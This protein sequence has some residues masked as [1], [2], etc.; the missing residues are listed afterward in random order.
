MDSYRPWRDYPSD[1]WI[2]GKD[3]Q[4]TVGTN[5]NIKVEV[6]SILEGYN[7]EG[8]VVDITN[9]ITNKAQRYNE[10]AWELPAELK[11]QE[12]FINWKCNAIY[13]KTI[14]FAPGMKIV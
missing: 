13:G 3:V 4:I 5:A 9:Q 14:F 6:R 7:P 1:P 10:I 11:I 12:R 2:M 8:L